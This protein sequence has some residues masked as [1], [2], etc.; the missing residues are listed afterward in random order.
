MSLERLPGMRVK[1]RSL[2]STVMASLY[3]DWGVNQGRISHTQSWGHSLLW[4][5]DNPINARIRLANNWPR[6]RQSD[7]RL[8]ML[9]SDRRRVRW[10]WK[11]YSHEPDLPPVTSSSC[12]V[13]VCRGFTAGSGSC[14]ITWNM[15]KKK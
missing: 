14:R 8:A 3:V 10:L 9:G 6:G 5:N 15:K 13:T 4:P 1:R 11:S 12:K 7:L 2:Q